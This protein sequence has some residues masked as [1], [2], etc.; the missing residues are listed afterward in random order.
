MSHLTQPRDHRVGSHAWSV[1]TGGHLTPAD[2]RDLLPAVIAAHAGNVAGRVAMAVHLNRG[3]HRR[4]DP[5]KLTPPATT[6]TRV[7]EAHAMEH[8][9]P[10]ILNHSRRTYAFG[11]ALGIVDDI[12]VDP[13][14]LYVAAL[15]HDVALEDGAADGVDFTVASAAVA[16]QIANDVG[17]SRRATETVLSA[18]TLHHSPDVRPSD[19]G[20]AYLLSAG[21]ALDVM[22][23]RSWDLAPSTVGAIVER[24]PRAGFKRAFGHAYRSEATRVP[25]GRARF[26]HRYAAVRLAIRLAPFAE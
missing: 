22:G 24:H 1:H 21:A 26:L 19:G 17:L 13:E 20:V 9:S 2:K 4:I 11:A 14:L 6:L 25:Q 8:L 15:L 10:T 3:R 16:S 5:A 23:L 18:I 12:A 7:A